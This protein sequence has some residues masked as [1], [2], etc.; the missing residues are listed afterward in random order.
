MKNKWVSGLLAL[1][2]SICL[3]LAIA[4]WA[5]AAI[6][7]IAGLA[8]ALDVNPT[9]T[10]NNVRDGAAGDNLASGLL[11][12][13]LYF[14][15]GT[16]WDRARGTTARGLLVDTGNLV[17]TDFFSV[18]RTNIT[19]ASVNLAFGFT[20]DKALVE[21]DVDNTA[22]VCLD[23]NGTTAVCPALDTAGDQ[24]LEPG[25]RIVLDDFQATSISVIAAS[26]TQ[27]FS[28]TAWQ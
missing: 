27:T 6:S 3:L 8:V 28:V 24:L 20:S 14:F 7:R 22:N 1:V 12:N 4:V 26:G 13:G 21:A 16:N 9:L 2:A 19:T 23:W 5:P 25:T 10:W 11:A 15:D 18:T 17:G